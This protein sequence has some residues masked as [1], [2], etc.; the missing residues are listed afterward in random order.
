[1]PE[2]RPFRAIMYNKERV[3]LASCVA[4]PYDVISP[5]QQ[6]ELYLRDP[7]NVIRLVLGR[8]ADRYGSAAEIFKKWQAEGI[9]VR[10]DAPAIYIVSQ[11]FT[12]PGGS[13]AVRKG[14]IAACKLEDFGKG[15]VFP[16]EKTLSHPKEDRFRLFQATKAMFSQIFSIYGDT[17]HRIKWLVDATM[18]LT[19]ALEV[20]QDGFTTIMWKLTNPGAIASISAA[21][22]E[23]ARA[24]IIMAARTGPSSRMMERDMTEP[25]RPSEP[26]FERV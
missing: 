25:S 14:F 15:S 11:H 13:L 26:N 23:P 22:E 6:E 18:R 10:D 7:A 21:M 2:I 9:L 5:E 3:S 24:V 19:P 1:M 16:H 4:P 17:A 12:L 8:E 20:E